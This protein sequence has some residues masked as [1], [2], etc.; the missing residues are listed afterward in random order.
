MKKGSGKIYNI[1]NA[2]KYVSLSNAG[3]SWDDIVSKMGIPLKVA[4][5]FGGWIFGRDIKTSEPLQ[6]KTTRRPRRP[7]QCQK[8]G[9]TA[10]QKKALSAGRIPNGWGNLLP[11]VD[12]R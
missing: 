1:E 4:I 10:V 2:N 9:S 11:S 5:T 12:K 6:R 8:N 3:A 7:V